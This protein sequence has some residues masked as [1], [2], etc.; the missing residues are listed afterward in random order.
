MDLYQLFYTIVCGVSWWCRQMEIWWK[1]QTWY[2][3]NGLDDFT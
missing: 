2:D 3:L 1:W